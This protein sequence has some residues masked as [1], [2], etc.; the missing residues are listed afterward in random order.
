LW[1]FVILAPS[2]NVM[3]YLLTYLDSV[4]VNQHDEY[5]D[6]GSF[7][8]KLIVWTHTHTHTHTLGLLLYLNP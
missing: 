5:L 4:I 8:L 7:S 3:T 1:C 2:I 6:Q